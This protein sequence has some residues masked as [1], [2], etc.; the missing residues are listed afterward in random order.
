MK[1]TFRF[2]GLSA[3]VLGLAVACNN[4]PAV[5]ETADTTPAPEE[6]VEEPIE[7]VTIDSALVVEEQPV[8]EKKKKTTVKSNNNAEIK[9][10]ANATTSTDAS[11]AVNINTSEPVKAVEANTNV[12]VD[13]DL[14]KKATKANKKLKK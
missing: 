11:A 3:L 7:E 14:S 5:E 6:I 4:Q 10:N 2:L 9:V 1:K 13:N 12:T 8:V